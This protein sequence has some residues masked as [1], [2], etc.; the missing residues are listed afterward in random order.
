MN[1]RQMVFL[2]L[3]GYDLFLGSIAAFYVFMVPFTKV[4]ESF[5][6]QV[7]HFSQLSLSQQLYIYIWKIQDSIIAYTNFELFFYLFIILA[8]QCTIFCII[9]IT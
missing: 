5:N 4:E 3:L 8:R 9:G 1:E 6:I 7:L 2:S